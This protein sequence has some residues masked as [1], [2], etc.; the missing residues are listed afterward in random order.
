MASSSTTTT[1]TVL[2]TVPSPSASTNYSKLRWGINSLYMRIPCFRHTTSH[3]KAC[4]C[5]LAHSEKSNLDIASIIHENRL[6]DLL[7]EIWMSRP[8][9]K[10]KN[11]TC[12]VSSTIDVLYTKKN[13]PGIIFS[14]KRGVNVAMTQENI[15][16]SCLHIFNNM[17]TQLVLLQET[18]SNL[19]FRPVNGM[20][21]IAWSTKT[22]IGELK[23]LKQIIYDSNSYSPPIVVQSTILP[24]IGSKRR[25]SSSRDETDSSLLIVPRD[26]EMVV[27]NDSHP[28]LTGEKK[29]TINLIYCCWKG[30]SGVNIHQLSV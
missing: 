17:Q 10:I 28:Y 6:F 16:Q 1:T 11:D 25:T 8:K 30:G 14:F 21:I 9:S 26:F 7:N 29:V 22:K 24:Q 5:G 23:F 20:D 13:Q 18:N 4:W 12:I 2:S 15:A 19:M 3:T 27:N